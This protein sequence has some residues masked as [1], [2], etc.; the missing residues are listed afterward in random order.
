MPVEKRESP[1]IQS[2]FIFGLAWYLEDLVLS[3]A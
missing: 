1:N 2:H 3:V